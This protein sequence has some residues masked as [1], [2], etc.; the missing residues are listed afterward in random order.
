MKT[1]L[2]QKFLRTV[3]G[4]MGTLLLLSAPNAFAF[5][6]TGTCA[7]LVTLAVPVGATPP[8]TKGYN[9]LATL[10]FTSATTGTIEYTGTRALYATTGVTVAGNETGSW[11]MTIAA[12]PITGSKTFSFTDT[13][14][15]QTISGN[16]YA[17]NGDRTI[18]VQGASDLFSGVCQF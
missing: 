11:P 2:K 15:S 13:V 18:L 10:T 4:G 17:V 5:P 8:H 16:M 3:L 7:M 6:T 12:G 9:I 1:N 14:Y